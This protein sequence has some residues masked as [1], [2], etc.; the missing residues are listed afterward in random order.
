[1]TMSKLTRRDFV[2]QSA[3]TSAA[4]WAAANAAPAAASAAGLGKGDRNKIYR[5]VESQ[6]DE[7]VARLQAWI[8]QPSVAAE[9]IGMAEGAEFMKKLALDAGFQHAEIIPTKGHPGVFA[10]LDA[11]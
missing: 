5:L 11:G 4:L 1:M 6:H 8:H 7:S 9:N 2:T 3:A 10:T